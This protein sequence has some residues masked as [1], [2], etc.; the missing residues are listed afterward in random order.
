VLVIGVRADVEAKLWT[1]EH[2][3]TNKI[4]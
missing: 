4:L 2:W 3:L 1:Q